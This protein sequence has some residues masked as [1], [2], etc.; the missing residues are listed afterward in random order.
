MEPTL[1]LR[2]QV[3]LVFPEPPVTVAV[4]CW[5]LPADRETVVGATV[6]LMAGKRVM[7]AAA[8]LVESAT[9]AAVAVTVCWEPTVAGAV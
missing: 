6:T 1:G 5:V 3:T 7:V 2:V 8:D 9:L 4:N